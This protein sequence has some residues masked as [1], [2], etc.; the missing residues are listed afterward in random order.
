[1]FGK[2]IRLFK[3]FG[4]EVK[5]DLSWLILAVLITWTL[6]Q[7]WFPH[8]YKNFPTMTYWWMGA[9]GALGLFASI[10]FHELSHSLVARKYGI[11]MRGITLFIFG[12]V[13]EMT[14]EPPSA[15]SEFMMAIAG[16][17]ASIVLG[18]GFYGI[19]ALFKDAGFSEPVHG[20][21]Q[22]LGF[23]NLVLAGFNLVPA[24]PLDGGRVLRSALWGWKN[25]LR[26]ATR[27]ASRI[28]SGF[29]IFLIVLGVF[30]F[31]KGNFI[32]G[33][34]WF[35]IGMF[36]RG[37]S[38]MSYQQLLVRRALEGESIARFMNQNPVT[39]PPSLFLDKL[40]ED[41]IYKYH[42]KMFP[43]TDG[44]ALKGCVKMSRVK[45]IPKEQ[46][47]QRKVEEI[48]EVC[49]ENNSISAD[50]DAV[51]AL[52]AIKRSGNSRLMVVENNHLIGIVSLKDLLNFLALK[53]D[54]EEDLISL[55]NS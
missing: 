38:Q 2:S 44:S 23:I 43:V 1:M 6:A 4:F 40:V 48:T 34:W 17:I 13:A 36:L 46:W 9:A 26:W 11:P 49:S 32:G 35:L 47:G 22:Y 10:V 5:I 14:Q 39:V 54:L 53:M 50:T 28:G 21:I 25:N 20:V 27:I 42:H 29:G 31:I 7:G 45:E 16:P 12:G 19:D 15:K 52:S 55:N 37:A 30:T 8:T 3:L 51:K 33:V 24:F 18:L 41:Y